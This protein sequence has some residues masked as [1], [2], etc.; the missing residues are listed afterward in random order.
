MYPYGV[1]ALT[2]GSSDTAK[3]Y[4][5]CWADAS[6]SVIDP[7]KPSQPA[8]SI[9]VDRHPTAMIL[10]ST[11]TR[12]Y[13]ANS[14]ADSISVIDTAADREIERINVKLG[15]SGLVGGSP[16]SVALSSDGSTMYVANVPEHGF[17]ANPLL[18]QV[19]T[20]AAREAARVPHPTALRLRAPRR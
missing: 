13:V 3:V 9:Q 6:I 17:E 11:G 8:A 2:R 5:S 12:L 18:A 19:T 15:E 20:Y 10:N 7:S 16:E 1:V 4:V 14:D